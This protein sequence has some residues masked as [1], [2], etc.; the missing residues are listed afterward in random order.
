MIPLAVTLGTISGCFPGKGH[1]GGGGGGGGGG[2]VAPQITSLSPATAVINT[3][4]VTLTITGTNLGPGDVIYFGQYNPLTPSSASS[5]TL[6]VTIPNSYMQ[7]TCSCLVEVQNVQ[8]KASN[9]VHF[10]IS[11]VPPPPLSLNPASLPDGT[12]NVSYSKAVFATGGVPP[13]TF[14]VSGLPADSISATTSA[15]S[16]VI[17]GTPTATQSSL[18]IGVSVTDASNTMKSASYT[19]NVDSTPATA[20][21]LTGQYAFLLTGTDSSGAVAM[22]GSLTVATDG[23]LSGVADFKDPSSLSEDQAI[24]G[25]AGSC[26]NGSSPNTGTLTF[27][28]NGTQRTINVAMGPDDDFGWL[29]ESDATGTEAYGRIELQTP[30]TFQSFF[31]SYGF[32]LAGSDSGGN[33]YAIAGALCSNSDF[34][35]TFLQ[36]DLDDNS[37]NSAAASPTGGNVSFSAPDGNGRSSTTAPFTFSGGATLNLTVYVVSSHV[38]FLLE[39]SPTSA[40]SPSPVLG[41]IISGQP[42]TICLPQA[43]G[44]NFTN[45]SIA[46]SILWLEG[47]QGAAATAAAGAVGFGGSGTAGFSGI[48][49]AASSSAQQLVNAPATFNVSSTGR[50][51]FEFTDNNS[52]QHQLVFYLDGGLAAYFLELSPN[53]EF[54]AATASTGVT[55]KSGLNITTGTLEGPYACGSQFLPPGTATSL[56][57]TELTFNNSASPPTVTVGNGTPEP[58]NFIPDGGTYQ[59]QFPG[60]IFYVISPTELV[61]VGPTGQGLAFAVQ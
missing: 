60:F 14:S 12:V 16:V 35:V 21:A 19:I 53:F 54:G 45:I 26:T 6:T 42:G 25:G 23:S 36:A 46:N 2:S 3:G 29:S 43:Q 44:G 11:P 59:G 5:T 15:S 7:A 40:G 34:G 1:G 55:T 51:T 56:P 61:L 49:T 41:G 28:A 33:Q 24:T 31:G 8:D 32:G 58:Y 47:G 20:C 30:G 4:P 50:G 27:T 18:T 17:S 39:S 10:T 52:T 13:Y 37:T 22:A 38:A 57:V 48:L 9:N